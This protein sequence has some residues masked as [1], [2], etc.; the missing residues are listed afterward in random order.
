MK[1]K[2]FLF[3]V[4]TGF[5]FTSCVRKKYEFVV[6]NN[7]HYYI[8]DFKFSNDHFSIPPNESIDP[9]KKKLVYNCLCFTNPQTSV[10][11]LKFSDSTG[12]YENNNGISAITNDF[13]RKRTNTIVIQ[14]NTNS[15]LPNQKLEIVIYR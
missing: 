3:L 5:L 11:V 1:Q 6:Y 14:L 10:A 9:F 2:Q 4:L 13:T 15:S 7:T 12:I 8:D